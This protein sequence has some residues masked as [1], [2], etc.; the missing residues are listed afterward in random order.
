MKTYKI[1]LIRHGLTEDNLRGIYAGHTDSPLCSQG[2]EQLAELKKCYVYPHADFVFSSPLK[3]CTETARLI[4]PGCEPVII[5]ALTEYNFGEFEGK[6]ADELHEKQPLFDRW[7][8]G[9][10]GI[11]P[12]FG[13][14]NEEFTSRVCG[15]FAKIV[16][17]IIKSDSDN[18][19]IVTHGG[20]I[21]TIMANFAIP[22]ASA[23][24]WLTPSGCGY[25][26]LASHFLWMSGRK[27]EA[28]REIPELPEEEKQ[29]NYYDGWDYYPND[30]DFDI[31]EYLN[32]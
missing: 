23:S 26:L 27:L 10:E 21:S 20:V 28:V 7:I 12:P 5:D 11:A 19:V 13:E 9:E 22:E 16:D 4:Y 29:G 8:R 18:V 1:H 14:T 15:G 32:D 17:G 25:T 2:A 24:E 31:S 3:R 6:T 30:D